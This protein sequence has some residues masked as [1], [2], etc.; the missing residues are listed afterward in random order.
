MTLATAT[1]T[2]TVNP[3]FLQE[4]K[5]VHS[6]LWQLLATV[7][8]ICANPWTA[9]V[10]SRNF[11]RML[12][13]LRDQLALQFALEEAYGYFEDPLEV[14][15]RLCHL[16]KTLRDEHQQL[17]LAVCDIFEQANAIQK[18]VVTPVMLEQ[19][20]RLFCPFDHQLRLHEAHEN[21]LIQQ[22]YDD[23]LGGNG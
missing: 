23:D 9:R 15:P 3:A 19:I 10:T 17:Y 20:E 13:Q 6:E 12:E 1:Y 4:I 8:R 16:A 21:E 14:A 18:R 5:E 11:L 2:V 22:A 7:R